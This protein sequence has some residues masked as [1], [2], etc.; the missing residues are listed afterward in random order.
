MADDYQG[1]KNSL[2]DFTPGNFK[3]SKISKF[4]QLNGSMS[5]SSQDVDEFTRKLRGGIAD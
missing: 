5:I 2:P 3:D 1:Y 4:A